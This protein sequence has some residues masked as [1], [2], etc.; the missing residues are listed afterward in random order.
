MGVVADSPTWTT[1]RVWELA[2]QEKRVREI[3][4]TRLR[5]C[6]HPPTE[7][8]KEMADSNTGIRGT[9]VFIPD[10]NWHPT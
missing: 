8:D 4:Q 7:F 6:Q 2:G 9:Q 1:V 5:P 10:W 3:Q